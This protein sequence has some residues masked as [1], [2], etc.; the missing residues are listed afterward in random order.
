MRI[1]VEPAP[2][3]IQMITV[4][5][6]GTG[7]DHEKAAEFEHDG[8]QASIDRATEQAKA[9]AQ[10]FADSLKRVRELIP[11]SP[12]VETRGPRRFRRD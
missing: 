7:V 3:G 8:T 5:L 4:T 10:G 1:F 12:K 9:Y 2:R 11:E 6:S